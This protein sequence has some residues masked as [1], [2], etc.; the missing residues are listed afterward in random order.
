MYRFNVLLAFLFVLTISSAQENGIESAT[1][2]KTEI[3][4]DSFGKEI[5]ASNA[6]SGVLMSQQY[7]KLSTSDTLSTKF[8]AK[9]IEVC[10]A[11][12][13]W[14]RLELNKGEEAMIKF[15]DY[16]FFVPKDITGREVVVNGNAFVNQMSVEE[17]KHYAK[18]GG[19]SEE[20]ITKITEPKKT[21]GFLADGVLLKK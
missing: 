4:S 15:K 3:S 10:Q 6:I 11:K 1:D 5:D 14:M 7:D 16:G 13:C 17:Q 19:K 18:D 20:E 12:G 21:Y 9:V 8:T 2:V